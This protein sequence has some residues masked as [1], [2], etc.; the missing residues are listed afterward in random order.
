MCENRVENEKDILTQ[1]KFNTVVII[2]IVVVFVVVV[3]LFIVVMVILLRQKCKNSS[4]DPE[5]RER[6]SV[7]F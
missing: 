5:G 1:N 4:V 6:Q 2:M 3:V 7:R